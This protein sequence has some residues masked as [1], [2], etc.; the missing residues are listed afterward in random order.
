MIEI[1]IPNWVVIEVWLVVSSNEAFHFRQEW[2]EV[3]LLFVLLNFK[4]CCNARYLIWECKYDNWWELSDTRIFL[5]RCLKCAFVSVVDAGFEPKALP[6]DK[7]TYASQ[8]IS[9]SYGC[10][11]TFLY[12]ADPVGVGLLPSAFF[13][14]FEAKPH[15]RLPLN[16]WSSSFILIKIHFDE[17]FTWCVRW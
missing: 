10:W 9:F 17:S 8:R 11:T 14:T 6:F 13:A 12:Y 3:D 2:A 4:L 7:G 1:F 16:T 5:K 15:P